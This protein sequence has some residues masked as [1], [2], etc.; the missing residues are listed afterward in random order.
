METLFI[1]SENDNSQN[2]KWRVVVYFRYRPQKEGKDKCRIRNFH[3]RNQSLQTMGTKYAL[4]LF[5]NTVRGIAF[6]TFYIRIVTEKCKK[7]FSLSAIES[8]IQCFK[9]AY[10]CFMYLV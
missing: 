8:F 1:S 2:Q 5:L 9:W 7:L 6:E 3:Y 4:R 10:I